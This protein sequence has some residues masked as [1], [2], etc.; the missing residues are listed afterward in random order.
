MM[1]MYIHFGLRAKI[2]GWHFTTG[3][4]GSSAKRFC[5]WERHSLIVGHLPLC[6]RIQKYNTT[7]TNTRNL[8]VSYAFYLT[9]SLASV[10]EREGGRVAE[11]I[12]LKS[13]CE[14]FVRIFPKNFFTFFCV[15]ASFALLSS[16]SNMLGTQR[17]IHSIYILDIKIYFDFSYG[18]HSND[19]FCDYTRHRRIYNAIEL[20]AWM[21]ETT[22][23]CVASSVYK[24][25]KNRG[26]V[27]KLNAKQNE[28]THKQ[29]AETRKNTSVF[30]ELLK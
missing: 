7:Q 4:S 27:V 18:A 14:K 11:S 25:K 19:N 15:V 17:F 16:P 6:L 30:Y 12:R 24:N 10:S 22:L 29:T 21:C 5:L 26:V 3:Q 20:C 9:S 13:W 28:W 23:K 1:N 8:C 2:A